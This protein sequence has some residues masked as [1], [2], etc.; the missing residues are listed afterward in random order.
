MDLN[1]LTT[2][3]LQT[4]AKEA[5]LP[6]WGTKMQLIQ[7]LQEDAVTKLQTSKTDE[8]PP[9][10]VAVASI[11]SPKADTN[12]VVT[13]INR[14]FGHA[15]K[16]FYDAEQEVFQFEGGIQGR[17]TTTARQPLKAILAVAA[18]YLNIH[19]QAPGVASNPMHAI[20]DVVR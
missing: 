5:G 1:A 15:V 17:T 2:A 3:K 18:S 6:T 9:V 14:R 12:A 10:P 11:S 20:G 19:E 13:E 8:V 16:V 4:Q 7:R